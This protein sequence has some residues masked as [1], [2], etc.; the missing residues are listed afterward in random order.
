[1]LG[2]VV[3]VHSGIMATDPHGLHA[4]GFDADHGSV[5]ELVCDESE[6]VAAAPRPPLDPMPYPVLAVPV[7]GSLV[8]HGASLHS[9]WAPPFLTGETLR[10]FL[11]VFLN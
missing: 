5:L 2:I 4:V 8:D 10:A 11:Q 1:M 7:N 3:M 6:G 9:G